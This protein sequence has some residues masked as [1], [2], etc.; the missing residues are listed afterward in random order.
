[1]K[2][3]I[4]LCTLVLVGIALAQDRSSERY[5]TSVESAVAGNQNRSDW[6]NY[7]RDPFRATSA[8][9]LRLKVPNPG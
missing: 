5:G 4:I 3:I 9:Q 8:L 6:Y 1:M 7:K 2:T